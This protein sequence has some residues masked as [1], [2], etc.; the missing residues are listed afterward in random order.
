MEYWKKVDQDGNTI[1]VESHSYP[2]KVPDAIQITKEEF[3]TYIASLPVV[4]P[5]PTRDPLAEIDELKAR[6]S[7]LEPKEEMKE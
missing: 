2:H 4:E 7:K 1:T 5:E 6:L 3:D